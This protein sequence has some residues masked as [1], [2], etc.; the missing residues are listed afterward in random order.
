MRRNTHAGTSSHRNHHS[1]T[2]RGTDAITLFEVFVIVLIALAIAWAAYRAVSPVTPRAE[3]T[4]TI[5]VRQAQT[6]WDI[7]SEHRVAGATTAETVDLIMSMN[8]MSDS[9]LSVGQTVEVPV[10]PSQSASVASR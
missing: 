5:K 2:R 4:A 8:G 7:A 3:S 10:A 9:A 1:V 6:L